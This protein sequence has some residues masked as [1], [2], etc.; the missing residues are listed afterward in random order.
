MERAGPKRRRKGGILDRPTTAGA[1]RGGINEEGCCE[2]F[3]RAAAA[4]TKRE[5]TSS[6]TW[7][8]SSV[9]CVISWRAGKGKG[10]WVSREFDLVDGPNGNRGR[11]SFVLGRGAAFVGLRA[12]IC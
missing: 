6:T 2:V 12:G 5:G 1:R 10:V 3:L 7:G 11:T 8:K 4:G 9:G